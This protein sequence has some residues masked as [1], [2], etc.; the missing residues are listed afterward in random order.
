MLRWRLWTAIGLIL[1]VVI[2]AAPWL[3][4]GI[5]L[6]QVDGR[7]PHASRTVVTPEDT[8]ALFS[9]L[10]ILEPVRLDPVSPYSYAQALVVG[11]Q[12][13]LGPSTRIAWIIAKSYNTEHLVD[14]RDWHLSGA[15]LT[16]WLTRNWASNELVA[17]ALELE[18]RRSEQRL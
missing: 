16:I 1:T 2:G 11:D 10:K 5:G 8:E 18:K 3:L 12:T 6:A 15:A 9:G 7:P 17:K 14:H 4:Y 13:I